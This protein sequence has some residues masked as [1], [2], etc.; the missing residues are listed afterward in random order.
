MD[1]VE[2]EGFIEEG[3]STYGIARAVG[4]SQTNVRY[5][6]RKHGL[7][8]ATSNGRTKNHYCLDCGEIVPSKFYG[9]MK[10]V[11]RRCW[12]I[13]TVQRTK[14][15]TT[16]IREFM[17]GRCRICNFDKYPVALEMHHLDRSTKDRDF[18]HMRCWSWQRLLGE[19]EKCV[20][21]CSNCHAAVHAGLVTVPA[22][23]V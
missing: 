11:C 12:N 9:R 20:L 10:Q 23:E 3:Y 14:E 5:W 16:R 18:H 22:S 4:T 17:G 6:L 2:L 7:A 1:R 15:T 13:R 8:T 19:A 21:L